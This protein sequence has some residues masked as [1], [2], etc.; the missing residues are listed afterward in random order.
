VT[1]THH[2][3]D[4]ATILALAAGTLGEAHGFAAATHMAYCPSCRASLREAERLGGSLLAVADE[5][6]VTDQCRSATLAS[7][8][9]V[10]PEKRKAPAKSV[11]DVPAVLCNLIGNVPLADLRWKKMGPG[12]ATHAIPLT[13]GGRTKLTLFRIE[14]GYRIPEH[15]HGGSELTVVLQG[16]FTDRTGHY[17]KGDVSD[18][19]ET[20]EHQPVID[21]G[22][23]CYCLFATEAP[24][25]FKSRLLRLLQPLL[26][27]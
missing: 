24:A 8:E 1:A 26:G 22:E 6:A 3:L 2:H 15:G 19:D 13:P 17:V 14:P 21:E 25:R 16:S 12:I 27:F 9:A 5:K 10:S 7:L 20:V 11:G 4:E 18:L 23:T